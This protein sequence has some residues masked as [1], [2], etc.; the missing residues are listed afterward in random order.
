MLRVAVEVEDRRLLDAGAKTEEI[1]KLVIREAIAGVAAHAQNLVPVDTGNLKNSIHPVLAGEFVGEIR[2]G[3]HEGD[4]V[5]TGVH[6]AP[7]VEF[8]TEHGPA[9]PYLGP[10]VEA[11][12]PAFERNVARAIEAGAGG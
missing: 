3:E 4:S 6:Y 10:A 12:R 1:L 9:Q 2:A 8:G 5:G 7:Y 11:V